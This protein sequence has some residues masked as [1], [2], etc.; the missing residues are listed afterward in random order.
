MQAIAIL[1]WASLARPEPPVSVAPAAALSAAREA[2]VVD[3]PV[4]NSFE[5]GGFLIRHDVPVFIDGRADFY[6]QEFM[7]DY[8]DAVRL[9]K[10]GA[11]ES[12]LDRYAIG[13]TMLQTGTPAALL[14]D[15][16]PGWERIHADET[17]VVHR[18]I[19]PN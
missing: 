9:A 2:G 18:R 10:P 5:F 13:W 8:L 14:L 7:S 4:L 17:A 1:I 12:L 6:G 19:P 15:R 16:L 11:L 3:S